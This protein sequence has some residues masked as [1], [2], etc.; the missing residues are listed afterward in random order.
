VKSEKHGADI[1]AAAK[2]S[3]I[4]ENSIIDF[5]SNI[6]PLG[7]PLSV[8]KAIINSI[9]YSSR[10]PDIHYRRLIEG[11]SVYENVP[12]SYIFPSNGAAE[13]IFRIALSL[14]PAYALLTAPTFSEYESALKTVDCSIKYYYLNESENFNITRSIFDE[15]NTVDVV[16]ICNPNN[17]TGQITDN[18]LLEKII[19]QCKLSDTIVVIDE[20]FMDFV[21]DKEKFSVCHLLKKYDNLIVLKA[22]T[23]I[24]AVPGIR[25]G[26]CMS[27]NEK[28]IDNL[29]KA[30]PPWNVSVPAQEAALAAVNEKDYLSQSIE[31]IRNQRK[32]L[33]DEIKKLNITSYESYANYILFKINDD[34]DLKEEFIKKGILIRSCANYKNLSDKYYRIAVKTEKENKLFIEILKGIMINR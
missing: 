34:I 9:K 12:V 22:F 27:S 32:Y 18:N 25:I 10:Y 26:Y 19:A 15:I 16:F 11:I 5:S 30:G 6:N 1:F 3:G 13:V 14:K 28:I 20:C 8:E 17:P 4:D 24:F 31:F 29:K 33:I 23:K 7:I 2:I 21:K